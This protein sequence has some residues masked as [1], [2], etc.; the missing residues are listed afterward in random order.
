M[1]KNFRWLLLASLAFVACNNDDEVTIDSNSSDG[2]PLTAG[3]ANFSKY[4]ALGNSLTSGFSDGALFKKGQEV[5]EQTE[6]QLQEAKNNFEKNKTIANNIKQDAA[7][8]AIIEQAYYS[9]SA[10]SNANNPTKPVSKQQLDAYLDTKIAEFKYGPRVIDQQRTIN[11]ML[12][13][14]GIDVDVVVADNLFS[15]VGTAAVGYALAS[16]IYIDKN[17]WNQP[18]IFMHEMA[19]IN[20]RL[21]ENTPAT[22]AVIAEAR[23]NQKLVDKIVK[24][25]DEKMYEEKKLIKE[26]IISFIK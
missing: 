24:K 6:E 16:T 4:V 19:H 18:A 13:A 1:I 8:R 7:R 20:Y 22:K 26:S 21:T 17:T 2:K 5:V 14:K 12:K 9:S 3:S 15:L 25:A 11:R 23:T 10:R